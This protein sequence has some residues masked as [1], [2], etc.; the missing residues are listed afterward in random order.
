[1]IVPSAMYK[2]IYDPNTEVA[3]AFL[4]P[5]INHSQ[6]KNFSDPLDYIQ[7]FQ[8]SIQAVEQ[9][10]NVDFLPMLAP[11]SQRPI[12]AECAGMIH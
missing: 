8:V 6:A 10:T 11:D 5:N 1:V 7:K 12:K 3:N 4:M 9:V 2:I